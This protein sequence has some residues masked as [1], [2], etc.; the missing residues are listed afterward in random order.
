[1]VQNAAERL[2]P[3]EQDS[4]GC[5][6]LLDMRPTDR[7]RAG[8]RL[9]RLARAT[10]RLALSPTALLIWPMLHYIGQLPDR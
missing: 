5:C 8:E 10:P 9:S 3:S 2:Q 6:Q 4:A 7:D 1:M